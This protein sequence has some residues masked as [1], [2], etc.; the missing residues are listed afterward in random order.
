MDKPELRIQF[1]ELRECLPAEDV[2]ADSAAICRRLASWEPLLTA[3]TVLA[4][5]AFR[6]EVDL[7]PLFELLPRIRWS[8]P[9]IVGKR[10]IFHAHN[11]ARLVRHPFGMLEPNPD[12]PEIAPAQIEV[13]LVPGV[14]FDRRGARLGFGGGYYDRF[15]PTTAALRVGITYDRCLVDSLP[16]REHDQRM[17]WVVTPAEMLPTKLFWEDED[18]PWQQDP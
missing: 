2:V 6:N 14:A 12:L 3:Q 9:R 13:V 4:Y 16:C 5:L 17:D 18:S 1:C 10:M 8:L 11:P 15:L 7:R